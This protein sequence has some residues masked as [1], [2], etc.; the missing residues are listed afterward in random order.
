MNK[1]TS[2]DQAGIVLETR[3]LRRV[4]DK[5]KVIV[6]DISLAVR[7]GETLAIVG[8]SGSGK[9]S[10]LRLLNRLD[11]PTSGTVLLNGVDY[12]TIPPRTLRRQVGMVMQSAYLFPGTVAENI[13][14]G[15][16]SRGE[17]V[18]SERIEELLE[19]V[20]L[21][22]YQ[23]RDISGL[24]GGEAQRVSLAR[25]L[26]NDPQVLLL[27]EPTS[28]LDETTR[29]GVEELINTIM[30][31]QGLTNIIVTHDM[32]QAT[33]MADRIAVIQAAQLK[34]IGTVE[35]VLNEPIA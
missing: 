31:S 4:V 8:P 5:D 10:F 2:L 15:P 3:N 16:R 24:S 6:N 28:A 27:D 1:A 18:S 14:F 25:T 34:R 17:Q 12:T 33:R 30:H 23:Q 32:A 21:A 29:A 11:E 20:Q 19:H 35:E 7:K 9:S 26:V 13:S 22:G